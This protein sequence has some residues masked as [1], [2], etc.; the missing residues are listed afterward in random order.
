MELRCY[1]VW[2]DPHNPEMRT[3]L[4]H[5]SDHLDASWLTLAPDRRFA[6]VEVGP[7]SVHGPVLAENEHSGHREILVHADQDIPDWVISGA[8]ADWDWQPCLTPP[9]ASRRPFQV[10]TLLLSHDSAGRLRGLSATLW[11]DAAARP[12]QRLELRVLP[13][14]PAHLP[15]RALEAGTG[16]RGAGYLVAYCPDPH[17]VA[18]LSLPERGWLTEPWVQIRE[19]S[20]NQLINLSECLEVRVLP[21]LRSPVILGVDFHDLI[22]LPNEALPLLPADVR[23]AIEEALIA[24]PDGP[25]GRD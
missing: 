7:V 9:A 13:E 2:G 25:G 18:A 23:D 14:I 24:L 22:G 19:R 10:D 16:E 1:L 6:R 17:A 15:V 8:P 20:W 12:L 21:V 3:T 11:F 5:C 4:L